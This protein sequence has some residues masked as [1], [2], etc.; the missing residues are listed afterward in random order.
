MKQMQTRKPTA[1]QNGT[2]A[3]RAVRCPKNT[4]AYHLAKAME[5][6]RRETEYYQRKIDEA[7]PE[8]ERLAREGTPEQRRVAKKWLDLDRKGVE[9]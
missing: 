3:R 8:I 9:A 7:R 4:V 2:G 5:A 6:I 1:I